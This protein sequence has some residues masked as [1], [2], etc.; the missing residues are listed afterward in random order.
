L[1][2]AFFDEFGHLTAAA[3]VL[4]LL[5]AA[6]RCTREPPDPGAEGERVVIILETAPRDL[7]PRFV[8]DASSTKVSKLIFCSLTTT[9]TDDLH[10]ALEV[11]ESVVPA[12]AE[13]STGEPDGSSAGGG[14]ECRHWVVKIRAGVFWHDGVEL[15]AEDVVYTYS[16]ILESEIASPFRGDLQRKIESVREENGEVHFHLAT[17]VAT[18]LTDLS[19]GL[20]PKHVLEPKAGLAG[21]FDDDFVGCGP[22][23]YLF[24]HKDQKV[25]LA[26]NK[27]YWKEVGPEYVVVRMVPDEATRVLSVMSG[28]GHVLVNNLSPPVV[29]RLEE[30]NDVRVLHKKA[31]CTTYL[32]FNLLDERL[33]D[34]RV[35]KAIALGMDRDIIVRDQFRDMAV[36]AN[37]IL[38]PIHWA[39]CDDVEKYGYDPARSR[40]LLDEAGLAVDPETGFRAKFTLKV[41]TDRFRR[42]IGSIIA[43][44]LA[45][46][47]IKVELLPLEL[48]TF[49]ADVRKGN[50]EMYILQL[51]EVVEP[52]ILRWLLHSQAAPVLTPIEGRSRYG[53]EDR[54][55]FPPRFDEVSGPLAKTCRERWF[56]RVHN[57]ALENFFRQAF[58]MPSSIG[59]GNRS[60]FFDPNLDCCLEL[61]YMTMDREERLRYYNEAQKIA[62]AG[63]PVLPLWH[64][65]NV[66]VVRTEVEGY[67]LLPINRYSPVVDVRLKQGAVPGTSL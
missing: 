61:G 30:R 27:L 10:P 11:A 57:Q 66:A 24:R 34:V 47:G 40:E 39:Y 4:L 9:E 54:T 14:S 49:L 18:F 29:R 65:D 12:C 22:F 21:T 31:A 63:I 56:P 7:D 38:P 42:N 5:C 55:L 23:R 48:S 16:S 59:S 44:K 1:R 3:A 45:S 2:S 6:V 17:P 62:A 51:P 15:T 25:V 46:I 64:E 43:Y 37:G 52:D 53:S 50:F 67:R 33:A 36:V 60:F 28:S 26:R 20:V 13:P 8:S 32:A 19:I 58:G 41:T 35:R